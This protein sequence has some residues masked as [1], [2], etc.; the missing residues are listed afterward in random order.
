M[1]FDVGEGGAIRK[2]LCARRVALVFSFSTARALSAFLADAERDARERP[3]SARAPLAAA[4]VNTVVSYS[5]GI[6]IGAA[7][8]RRANMSPAPHPP[9]GPK[10]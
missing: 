7:H 9:L 3:T 6:P 8:R 1:L 10:S 4:F 2:G 5:I